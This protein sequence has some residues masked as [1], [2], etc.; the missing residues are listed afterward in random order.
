M[1]GVRHNFTFERLSVPEVV[2]VKP[3]KFGDQRGYFMETYAAAAFAGEGIEAV[4]VQDN[5]S[6]SSK[7][8]TVRGLHFQVPP[9]SQAKLVRVVYGAIFDVAVD[10]RQ[11]SPHY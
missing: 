8:G 2:L 4:F 7:R 9:C 1:N 10:L 11:S 5:Q 6:L 3:M